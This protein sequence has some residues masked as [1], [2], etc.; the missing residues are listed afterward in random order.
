MNIATYVATKFDCANQMEV[1]QSVCPVCLY[2]NTESHTAEMMMGGKG[3]AM[4][5]N[6]WQRHITGITAPCSHRDQSGDALLAILRSLSFLVT[7]S[8][9]QGIRRVRSKHVHLCLH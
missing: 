6:V 4:Y 2:C 7:I 5:G 3:R 8:Y 1:C 9:L